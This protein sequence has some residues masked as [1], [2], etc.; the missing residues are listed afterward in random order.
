MQ[1]RGAARELAGQ[2]HGA[3]RVHRRLLARRRCL[4]A[5]VL[6]ARR[7]ALEFLNE[8]GDSTVQAI[9]VGEQLVAAQRARPGP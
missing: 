2:L 8:L 7:R 9:R 3:G 1:D 6:W 5:A 4:D